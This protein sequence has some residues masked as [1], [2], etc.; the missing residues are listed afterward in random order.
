MLRFSGIP[1]RQYFRIMKH[2]LLLIAFFSVLGLHAQSPN[3]ILIISDDQSFNSIGYTSQGQVYTPT[4]DSLAMQ[5]I[6][7]T[8]AHHPVTVCSPSR[9]SILS[10][11]FSG[12]CQGEEYLAKFPP[13]TPTRTENNCELT[14]SEDHLAKILGRNGYTTGF[15]GKSHIMEH[16]ILAT[17][18]WPS[19][20]LEP[21]G[22]TDDPYDPEVSAKMKHNH[23]VYQSIVRSYGFDYADG[24]YMANV[25]ELRNDALNIHNLEWTVDKARKFIEQEKDHP[26]FLMFSTTLHHGPVPWTKQDGVYWSSFDADPKLTGEGYVDTLWNFM[27]TRQEIQ[28]KYI[29]AGFP[30][31]DA[32]TL[33]LDEGVQAIHKKLVELDLE[34]NTLIIFMPD[35][36]MWRHGK[37]TLY[38]FGLKVPMLMYWKGTIAAGSEYGGLVQTVDFLPTILDITGIEIPEGEVTDGVSLKPILDTGSGEIHASLFSELGYA[39]AVKTKDWKYIAV[40]YPEDIQDKID[41]GESFPG[42]EDGIIDMPYLTN[43]KHLGYHA[44]RQNPHY[45]ETDQLYNLSED[46]AETIN[47]YEQHPGVLQ[48]M[49]ELLSEYLLSFE[50]R[51]FREFS[52]TV[53]DP[54]SRATTPFP[55]NGSMKVEP[56]SKIS[57]TSEYKIKSQDVYFGKTDPPP[58]VGNQE[59][60]EFDPGVLDGA[61]TY[62]WRIDEKNENGTTTGDTWSFTTDLALASVPVNPFPVMNASS[63]RKNIKLTWDESMNASYYKLYLGIGSTEYLTDLTE[64][65]YDPGILKSNSVY[66]WRV[67]AVNSQG[68]VT[69]GTPWGFR[70]G[71]GNIAPEAEIRVSSVADQQVYPENHLAD[72][73][74][75]MENMGEWRSDGESMP[76][77]ELS[78]EE[79]AVVDQVNLY[80]IVGTSSHVLDGEIIFSDSSRVDSGEL[81]DSGEKKILRFAPRAISSLAFSVKQGVGAIGLAE[82]E[83]FDT[84]MYVSS[85]SRL[86]EQRYVSLYPNPAYGGH[87]SIRGLP[88]SEGHRISVYKLDGTL[89]QEIELKDTEADLDLSH[90][91]QGIY[92]IRISK[93]S[94]RTTRKLVM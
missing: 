19:Y 79:Q 51:P 35:H 58:F 12:R 11:K 44:S 88:K 80:D 57:W 27:P 53:S 18:N 10:G 91:G 31:K 73:I 6:R 48:E 78:W 93:G 40:R 50:N 81:P 76:W 34:E 37:A 21:Y 47:L 17:A 13:G 2:T 75:L 54:P 23:E 32:Y 60:A 66:F 26:F 28:D 43:N 45:F 29:S 74:Y 82:I 7:F 46:S 38:D 68:V 61:T 20:G 16:D 39:R 83:V 3:I 89:A 30:E 85:A 49:R 65:Q 4:I 36:G 25:K 5:G 87:V 92:L 33:L 72:G 84:A 42:F 71:Y 77:I 14:L 69:T 55:R 41:R 64:E 8:N 67:D 86:H 1:G 56:N 15:V 63:V 62:Y 52:L 90:L 70:T 59:S 9:Y 24:I 94:F 22:Q